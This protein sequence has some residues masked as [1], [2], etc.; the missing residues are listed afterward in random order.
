MYQQSGRATVASLSQKAKLPAII[1]FGNSCA[2]AAGSSNV[3]P[4][5]RPQ[6]PKGWGQVL[7][8]LFASYYTL[9]MEYPKGLS[10]GMLMFQAL[11]LEPKEN[12]DENDL[13]KSGLEKHYS[14]YMEWLAQ[15]IN[16]DED[17]EVEAK[18]KE[19]D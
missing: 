19:D 14:R 16:S 2:I 8:V 6:S 13:E 15:N 7:T 18:A 12:I 3:I 9:N 1:V 17:E 10:T 5:E 11:A 4:V